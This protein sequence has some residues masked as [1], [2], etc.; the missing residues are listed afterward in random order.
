MDSAGYVHYMHKDACVMMPASALHIEGNCTGWL[1][2]VCDHV[3]SPPV[4]SGMFNVPKGIDEGW[5]P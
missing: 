4:P 5:I 2:P 3:N 1:D